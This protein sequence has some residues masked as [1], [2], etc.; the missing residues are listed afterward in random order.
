MSHSSTPAAPQS[1]ST[2]RRYLLV[3]LLGFVAGL[4]ATVMGLRAIQARM[5]SFP[6]AL[7]QV[8]ARQQ[9]WLS[10]S[11]KQNRCTVSDALPR[12]QSLRALANDMELA[13][14]GLSD[15]QRF[16]HHAS[17]FRAN[18]DA[19]LASVPNDCAAFE[20]VVRRSG[21]GCKNCHQDFR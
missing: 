6:S 3:L 20:A 9:H 7:M 16:Q 13:F 17:A 1:P 18:L 4:I 2:L 19:A 5:D 12:L 14:P 15:D 8:M 21:E 11:H 10:E